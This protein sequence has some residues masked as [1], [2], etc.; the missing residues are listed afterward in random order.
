MSLWRIGSLLPSACGLPDFG[1]RQCAQPGCDIEQ[2]QRLF[3]QQPRPTAEV[4][5]L[6]AACQTAGSTD[7]RVYMFLGVMA[8]DAG[9]RERAIEF[10]QKAHDMA[11]AGAQSGARARLHAGGRASPARRSQ[12]YEEILARDPASRPA[13]LGAGAGRAQPEPPR[14]GPRA[15]PAAARGQSRRTPRPS[16]GH[17]LAGTRQSQ[18]RAG[19]RRLRVRADAGAEQRRGEDRPVEGRRMST[20]ICSMPMARMV[21]TAQGTSWGF[22]ARGMAGITPFDTLELGWQFISPTSCRRCRPSA[23]PRCRRTTSPWVTTG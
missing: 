22:G 4:E 9:D 1:A 23:S 3:G 10:L 5:R 11:P 16:N 2:A 18:P 20:A 19:A 17:G 21:S 6:L 14:R 8:R 7:Y 13:L 15:L 12:V